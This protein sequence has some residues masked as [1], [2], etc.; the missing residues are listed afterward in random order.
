MHDFQSYSKVILIAKL[1]LE[2]VAKVSKNQN[3]PKDFDKLWD[4]RWIVSIINLIGLTLTLL[5]H[6]N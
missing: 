1:F 5:C 3:C 4:M 6:L 2:I